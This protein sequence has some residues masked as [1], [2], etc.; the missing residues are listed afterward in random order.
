MVISIVTTM[1]QSEPYLAEF[2]RRITKS[3]LKI[4]N[5]YEIIFVND[6]SP[7]NSQEKALEIFQSDEKVKIIDLSRNFGH[8]KAIMTGLSY[9]S[10][11]LVF[12]IDCDLEEEPEL[13]LRFYEEKK[14]PEV[15]VI[16]GVQEVRKG[17]FFERISGLIFFQ[18][19]NLLA[20]QKI[21]NNLITVRLMSRRYVKALVR[22]NERETVI[23]GL[24]S[25]TGFGQLGIKVNKHNK[26]A[27]SYDLTRKIS[28]LVN[29]ITSFSNTPLILIFY[30]GS[31]IFLLSSIAAFYLIVRRFFFGILLAGWP[32]LIVSIWLLGGLTIF[33][34]GIIGIY[35]SKI[36]TETKQ[37]PYTIIRKIYN[38]KK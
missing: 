35:L 26:G 23:S 2:Y 37:R 13:L 22:H 36:F 7:D 31:L 28:H 9:A 27:S 8:H 30:I 20:E 17:K 6:G 33:C 16:Y 24:W 34:L 3:V 32:S 14:R 18:V 21:P 12:L 25:I 38:H 10:G 15:D 19:F 5:D 1:Y 11:E 29:C 4:T